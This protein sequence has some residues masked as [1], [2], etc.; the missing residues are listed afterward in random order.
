MSPDDP[1]FARAEQLMK[2]IAALA[3]RMGR[4]V[5]GQDAL[6]VFL[7]LLVMTEAAL[8]AFQADPRRQPPLML[9]ALHDVSHRTFGAMFAG[10]VELRADEGYSTSVN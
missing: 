6:L 4:E 5:D 10:L 2:E 7:A 1:N 3:E 9:Q 8:T